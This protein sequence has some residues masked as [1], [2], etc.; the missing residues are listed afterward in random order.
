MI[1]VENLV[2]EYPTTRA[3]HGVSFSVKPTTI[4]ALVGPNGAGKTTL[5]RCLAALEMPFEGRVRIDGLDTRSSPRAI[6]ARLGYLPD[7][8]GLY[9]ALSVRRCLHFAA[10]MHGIET[11]N[12]NAAV[13]KAAERVGLT[14]RMGR[15]ASELS[16]GLRQR[17]AIGQAIVHEPKVLMLDEPASGL[18]PEARRSL[19]QLL[20]S[21]KEQGM[22]LVVSSHILSELEGYCSEMI[23]IDDG[24]I[25]GGSAVKLREDSRAIL[26]VQLSTARADLASFLSH[27]S[28]IELIDADSISAT[29]HFLGDA[30]ARAELLRRVAA[31][32]FEILSFADAPRRLEEAYF[33]EVRSHLAGKS[34]GEPQ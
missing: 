10:R 25:V 28:C 17:L 29:F 31:E 11:V 12:V 7:F 3:L 13:I 1:E 15:P 23:I 27:Q 9:D 8:F 24:Q 32:G 20:V 33:T 22:T 5:L 34:N 2:Y 4:A 6:H 16:R 21:L 30:K 14:D 26:R 18:D 19:S